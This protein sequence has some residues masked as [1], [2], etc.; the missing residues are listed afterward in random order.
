MIDKRNQIRGRGRRAAGD[1]GVFLGLSCNLQEQVRNENTRRALASSPH[2]Q[3]PGPKLGVS[4]LIL[5]A[6]AMVAPAP[7]CKGTLSRT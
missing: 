6:G 1:V 4:D 2:P 7:E 5:T 3:L